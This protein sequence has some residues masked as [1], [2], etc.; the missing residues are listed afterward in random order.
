MP[1]ARMLQ[2]LNGRSYGVSASYLRQVE[3]DLRVIDRDVF[4]G[5][6]PCH[7]PRQ[8]AFR[9][10]ILEHRVDCISQRGDLSW[11]GRAPLLQVG[12]YKFQAHV[13]GIK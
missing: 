2:I 6:K 11:P 9:Q 7:E 1:M 13:V 10:L 8:L 4:E 5:L 3:H 12:Y